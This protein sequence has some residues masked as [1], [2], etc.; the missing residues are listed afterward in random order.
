ME[1]AP[2]FSD[3]T[4]GPDHGQAYWLKSED[5][6]R[7]RAGVWTQDGAKGTVLLFPGRTEYIEKYSGTAHDLA[8][9]GYA[10]IAV[11]WRGQG[12]ADRL[13]RNPMSGHVI[14]FDDYLKDIDA[15]IEMAEQ[16]DLP[17]PWHLL[18]HS[19]GG[20][21]GLHAVMKGLPV[22]SC[23]FSGPMWGISISTPM[24]PVAWTLSTLA[25]KTGLGHLFTPG[26]SK[27]SYVLEEAFED[28]KLTNYRPT[29]DFMI[30]QVRAQPDL[31]LGG[32][33]MGWLIESLKITRWMHKQPSPDLPCFTF[34]GSLEAIVDIPRIKDRMA[35]WP[36][37]TLHVV[38][39]GHHELLMDTPEIR[40][41]ITRRLCAHFDQAATDRTQPSDADGPA[42]TQS[43]PSHPPR[44][45]SAVA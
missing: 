44:S 36:N 30:D 11:D 34:Y 28:N 13:T 33:S 24:R 18:G 14:K 5:G 6:V 29:Y 22:A 41:D 21:I 16:L 7:I 19:M 26:T 20:G 15:V 23:A 17:K 32:P 39:G 3:I 12:L 8:K 42:Q 31:G 43:A 27:G 38:E 1:V 25:Q 35:R 37:G 45:D 40:A 4:D 9:C 10:T 2:F